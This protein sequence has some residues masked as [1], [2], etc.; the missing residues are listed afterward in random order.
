M[1]ILNIV[2]INFFRACWQSLNLNHY[3]SENNEIQK[4]I[5]QF[6]VTCCNGSIVFDTLKK[7]FNN[8]SRFIKFFIKIVNDDGI[9]L[10]GNTN[11]S[12]CLR[13]KISYL[14]GA[15]TLVRQNFLAFK[16]NLAQR[17]ADKLKMFI[18]KSV[19]FGSFASAWHLVILI[20]SPIDP[21]AKTSAYIAI[22]LLNPTSK[23]KQFWDLYPD[24]L[25][26]LVSASAVL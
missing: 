14:F 5:W 4:T 10:V 22:L 24:V 13:N 16:S 15:I 25:W 8:V 19:N 20:Y 23:K 1:N 21:L 12:F 6:V 3:G 11:F 18:Y 2:F 17:N 9:G 26:I 7:S